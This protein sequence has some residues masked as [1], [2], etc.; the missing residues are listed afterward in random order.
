MILPKLEKLSSVFQ[1][2][3]ERWLITFLFISTVGPGEKRKVERKE[4]GEDQN[5]EEKA[6][7]ERREQERFLHS[8][9]AKEKD[10]IKFET[11]Y[12]FTVI[13]LHLHWAKT[14]SIKNHLKLMEILLS[15]MCQFCNV[16]E[17]HLVQAERIILCISKK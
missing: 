6:E 16:F 13:E 15:V 7:E 3:W 4:K 10:E 12:K 1:V 2:P 9:L 5:K 14:T 11:I 8:R 17:S